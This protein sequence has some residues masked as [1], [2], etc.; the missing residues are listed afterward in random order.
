MWEDDARREGM[1]RRGPPAHKRKKSRLLNPANSTAGS[2]AADVGA[3]AAMECSQPENDSESYL[4][5]NSGGSAQPM[6]GEMAQ[7]RH[8]SGYPDT[9]DATESLLLDHYIRRFSRTY[10]TFSGPTNPFL[11]V[12]L[13]LSMQNR[14]VLDSLLALSG[15]QTW[16][17]RG[18]CMEEAT[19]KLRQR[20]LRG[21]RKLLMKHGTH[22][23]RVE[24]PLFNTQVTNSDPL[25][26]MSEEDLLFLSTSCVLL[27][28][29]EKIAGEG[30]ENWTPHLEFLARLFSRYSHDYMGNGSSGAT[31]TTVEAFRFLYN[32]FLY[33]DLVRSISLQTS[34]L[35]DFY[36]RVG[37]PCS[38]DGASLPRFFSFQPGL[39]AGQDDGRYYYPHLIA[40]ISA[41]DRT[42]TDA[43]IAAWD[44]RVDWLPSFALTGV[45]GGGINNQ[46]PFG[47][48]SVVTQPPQG[49][50]KDANGLGEW[51]ERRI[52][53]ELYRV[54]ARVY[55]MQVF[56]RSE[57]KDE[58]V[59]A[60]ID[61]R[62]SQI[63]ILASW[64]A[65]LV[66]QLPEG[67]VFENALLWPI[68]IVARELTYES[69]V[70][71]EYIL[72][73]LR[74]LERR[75]QMKHFRRVQEILLKH[76]RK[77][78]KEMI[79]NAGDYMPGSTADAILVG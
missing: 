38:T 55:R 72:C 43:D 12:L 77:I 78:D 56:C 4:E 36:L 61:A 10:P 52:I 24:M 20:A 48:I 58:T 54:A 8:L 15:A 34:P 18:F 49:D 30:K 73:R 13:P 68:G 33:N 19:L 50:R 39:E 53:S 44:G 69:A 66:Q 37:E 79:T 6:P 16:D 75:F 46:S 17:D 5:T 3:I 64:A 31:S 71:R 63:S 22:F 25:A 21:C 74:S 41:G 51:E 70:E 14:V 11:S 2:G 35:S 67:S 23:G 76:W 9:L 45:H 47:G 65:R 42:V 60:S 32:L 29:Y 28:L 59:S 40:R 27:L 1:R 62:E 26:N 57:P 7:W